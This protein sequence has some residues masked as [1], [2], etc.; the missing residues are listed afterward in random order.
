MGGGQRRVQTLSFLPQ[1]GQ[2]NPRPAANGDVPKDQRFILSAFG[3]WWEQS[4]TWYSQRTAG[5]EQM[6]TQH[7]GDVEELT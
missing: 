6:L 5:S 3:R 1:A 7:L 2:M 4:C